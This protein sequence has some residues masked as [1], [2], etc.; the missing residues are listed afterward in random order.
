MFKSLFAILGFIFSVFMTL[1]A[2][3]QPME[4]V[5]GWYG[6][7]LDTKDFEWYYFTSLG[8]KP[9]FVDSPITIYS[10]G[11]EEKEPWDISYPIVVYK[12]KYDKYHRHNKELDSSEFNVYH[13][14]A[15]CRI[16]EDILNR[17]VKSLYPE[18]FI[19]N[20]GLLGYYCRVPE[21]YKKSESKRKEKKF[22]L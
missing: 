19:V 17:W 5:I 12:F 20:N 1:P 4:D 22:I 11:I 3:G 13:Y 6:E 2:L 15:L 8:V 7:P 18:N 16:P 9:F 10:I 14:R 21:G